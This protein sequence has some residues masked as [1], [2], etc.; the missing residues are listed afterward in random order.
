MAKKE[1]NPK[2]PRDIV[3]K[4]TERKT[5]KKPKKL[6]KE[7]EDNIVKY[8][9]FMYKYVG[10]YLLE[11]KKFADFFWKNVYNK[12]Y[13]SFLK[14]ANMKLLPEEYFVSIFVS[15]IAS[16]VLVFALS[17]LLFFIL[18][19][20][21]M[22]IF[23]VGI[24][25]VTVFGIFLY[26]YPILKSDQRKK[27]IDASI[28]YLLPYLKILSKELNIAKII[29]LIDEFLIYKEIRVEFRRIR[30]MSEFLGYDVQSSIRSAMQSCPSRQL[31]DMMNDL[32][33]ITN[34]GGNIYSYLERKLANMN[35]EI[36]AIEKK[37]ID[38]LLIF[39][40]I[41]VVLLLIAP[42]FFTVMVSILNLVSF[43]VDASGST[44]GAGGS[45]FIIMGVLLAMPFAYIMFML[46]I[47]FSKPLYTRLKPIKNANE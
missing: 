10:R 3:L 4:T 25:A 42:L 20:Y 16:M 23:Y 15:T 26:N 30:Y 9:H 44:S 1:I 27:E 38:T 29:G 5:H 19:V 17:I 2:N 46:L 6:P 31:A 45:F 47:Q 39:S 18:P 8:S 37:N 14:Q 34:S 41:Y 11:R 32:V 28:P 33:T 13:E 36:E 21:S 35:T 24:I 40:Q 43:G 12:K 22:I 7:D